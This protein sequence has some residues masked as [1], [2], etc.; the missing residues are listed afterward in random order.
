MKVFD[1]YADFYDSYYRNKDY[2]AEVNFV[3][4]LVKQNSTPPHCFRYWLWNWWSC[5]SFL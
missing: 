3:L 2:N 1:K 4:D 5:D